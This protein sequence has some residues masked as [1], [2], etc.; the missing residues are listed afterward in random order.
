MVGLQPSDQ[1]IRASSGINSLVGLWLLVC[2]W[3]LDFFAVD[4]AIAL[5]VT[6]TGACLFILAISRVS[7]P[8]GAPVLS[9]INRLLGV[10]TAITPW[11]FRLTWDT[12]TVV[13][14]VGTGML[15][16]ICASM[17]VQMTGHLLEA[18]ELSTRDPP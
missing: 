18:S 16:V 9:R 1:W 15:V 10:W 7:D 13:S 17:S 14:L 12:A 2:P 8:L 11:V 5:S 4:N 6:L 3:A